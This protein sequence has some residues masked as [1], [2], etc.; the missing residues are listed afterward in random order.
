[1]LTQDDRIRYRASELAAFAE[2]SSVLFCLASASLRVQQKIERF[3][4]VRSVIRRVIDLG[5]PAI[6]K[7]YDGRI[8]RKWP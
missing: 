1:M 6:F 8:E 3:H 5:G 2:G 7:V 4:G